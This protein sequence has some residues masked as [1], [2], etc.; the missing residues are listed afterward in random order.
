MNYI[1][2]VDW[3]EYMPEAFPA[4]ALFPGKRNATILKWLKTVSGK[5]VRGPIKNDQQVFKFEL[6]E[7]YDSF[8]QMLQSLQS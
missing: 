4:R 1:L 8:C 3:T 5:V 6:G 7:D 2:E